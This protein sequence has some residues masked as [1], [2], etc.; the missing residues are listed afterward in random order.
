MTLGPP[1]SIP[2]SEFMLDDKHGRHPSDKSMNPFTCGISGRTYTHKEMVNRVDLL[3]RALSEEL[4][5]QPNQGSE[6]D[7]VAGIFALNTVGCHLLISG[8]FRLK[9]QVDS[10]TLAYAV[11]R[12]GGLASPAN[13]AYSATE[14]QY[15]LESSGSK[16][17]FTVS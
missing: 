11:H 15:Q 10:M 3:A 16:C 13:A 7:K 8:V 5:W 4:G 9:D 1:D 6:W 2:I 17:L 12:L 14:L